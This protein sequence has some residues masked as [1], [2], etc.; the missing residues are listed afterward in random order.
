MK[1]EF[2]LEWE[3]ECV[4]DFEWKMVQGWFEF[5]E[6]DWVVVGLLNQSFEGLI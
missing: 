6:R 3:F 2:E 1:C 5:E 4:V